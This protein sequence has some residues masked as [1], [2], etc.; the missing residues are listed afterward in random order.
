MLIHI[1]CCERYAYSAPFAMHM[2]EQTSCTLESCFC[3]MFVMRCMGR[4][5]QAQFAQD[6]YTALMCAAWKGRTECVRLLLDAGADTKLKEK[7]R[8]GSWYRCFVGL[9]FVH[10]FSTY[11][12]IR[13]RCGLTCNY[14]RDGYICYNLIA[15]IV[16]IQSSIHVFEGRGCPR[17]YNICNN[18]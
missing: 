14:K 15:F 3:L 1:L 13:L 2:C 9:L 5:R 6:G 10:M 8:D 17:T 7:V 16:K 12:A 4:W 18:E 11:F